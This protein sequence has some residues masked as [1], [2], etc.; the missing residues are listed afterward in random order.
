MDNWLALFDGQT[1]YQLEINDSR[2][3]ADV[4]KFRG[5]EALNEPFRWRIEFTSSQDDVAAEDVLMKYATLRMLSGRVVQGII[6]AFEW[7]GATADQTHYSVTISSRMA[8]LANTRRCAVYQN[9]SVPEL[10]EQVLRAHGLEGSDFEFRLEKSYPQREL[11]TQWRES[12]LQFIQRLLS[13]VGIWFR[14][15]VNEVTGLD[16]LTFAD[17]Q[18]NY[19]FDVHLPYQEPSALYDG[20]AESVWG[21][22]TWH[23]TV[24]GLVR[25]RDYNYRAATSRTGK[26]STGRTRR[27]R[28]RLSGR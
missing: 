27:I 16:T 25:T 4:L 9:L 26:S 28:G 3:S 2:V 24:T 8:L 10:V 15:G 7:L 14:S 11:I 13:E 23:N 5:R 20:A 21:L 18:L 17:S 22:R 6:I 12:D 19:Q 1:R